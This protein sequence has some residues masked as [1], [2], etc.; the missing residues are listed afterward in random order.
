MD[1]W[2]VAAFA[3]WVIAVVVHSVHSIP[4]K[5]KSTLSIFLAVLGIWLSYKWAQKNIAEE[6]KALVKD[7]NTLKES[8]KEPTI[9]NSTL[10]DSIRTLMADHERAVAM[11][12]SILLQIARVDSCVDGHF[13]QMNR[14]VSDLRVLHE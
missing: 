8:I 11:N 12:D 9:K 4:P 2:I 7:V 5:W 6:I 10:L 1:N 3:I 14:R 13:L